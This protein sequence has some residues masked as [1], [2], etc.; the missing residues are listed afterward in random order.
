MKIHLFTAALLTTV[1]S[2]QA[3]TFTP[4]PADLGDLDH[5]QATSWGINWSLPA[6]QQITGAILTFK[7]IW[8]WQVEYDQLYIHLLDNPAPGVVYN[9]D[10]TADNVYSDYFAG[11]GTLLTTWNDPNGGHAINFDLVINFS[12]SQ[13]TALKNYVASAPSGGSA[14]FGFGFD[15]DCHYFNDGVTFQITTQSVPDGGST[16]ALLGTSL[17]ALGFLA[18]RRQTPASALK[19]I[20]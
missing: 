10:N 7:N 9:L 13:L 12:A 1:F 16:I 4:S 6:G 11:K 15:P 19:P 3:V 5:H 14:N 8:D 2:T 18:S 20:S 17:L